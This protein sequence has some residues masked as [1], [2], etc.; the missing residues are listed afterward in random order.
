MDRYYFCR[1]ALFPWP[2]H[3]SVGEKVQEYVEKTSGLWYDTSPASFCAW[4]DSDSAWNYDLKVLP[5]VR[6]AADISG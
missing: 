2:V 5:L 6:G 4:L 3:S 1:P